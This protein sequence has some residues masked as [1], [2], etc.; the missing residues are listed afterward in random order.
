M[1]VG[2][3]KPLINRKA[4]YTIEGATHFSHGVVDVGDGTG[5]Q[6]WA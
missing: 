5:Q 4:H 2:E 6:Q 1:P 3:I